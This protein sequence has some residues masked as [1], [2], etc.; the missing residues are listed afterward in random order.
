MKIQ[1]AI[2]VLGQLKRA[3]LNK[4]EIAA[5]QAA[6]AVLQEISKNAN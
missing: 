1:T 6:I 5:V 3:K 4:R 2:T